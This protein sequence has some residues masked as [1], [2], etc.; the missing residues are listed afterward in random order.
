MKKI[1]DSVI[2]QIPILYLQGLNDKEIAKALQISVS[3][4]RNYR[5]DNHIP[6]QLT[7][8][9]RKV[10]E[11]RKCGMVSA[12]ITEK[13]NISR[14]QLKVIVRTIGM[15]FTEE[16]KQRSIELGKIKAVQNQ[17]GIYDRADVSRQ[18][19]EK[20]CSG[21][22]YVSGF[23]NSDGFMKVKCRKCDSE[24]ERSAVTIRHYGKINCPVC[25]ENERLQKQQERE[26]EKQRQQEQREEEKKFAIFNKE[27]KRCECCGS[28]FFGRNNKYCSSECA[29]RISNS[30]SKDKRI[31]KMRSVVIDSNITLEKLYQRDSGRCWICGN[32]CDYNDY[33]RTKEGHFIVGNT[34]PSI[35][36]VKPLSKG[37]L[38]SWDNVKLAHHYCNTLKS[39]KVV[40]L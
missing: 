20:N 3:R 17:H 22:E 34:Y 9:Q 1:E 25:Q 33:K 14:K 8:L 32:Q 31:K 13:L 15:P 30:I 35:D 2:N 29:K 10:K 16:E 37:G 27:F 21:F 38:H 40:C 26:A 18:Y 24:F 19:I 5:C 23:I 28:L 39:N 7:D 12:E 4:V 6:K 36:H 11:Y